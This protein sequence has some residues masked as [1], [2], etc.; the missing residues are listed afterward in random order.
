[1]GRRRQRDHCELRGGA[2]D[3]HRERPHRVGPS[4]DARPRRPRDHDSEAYAFVSGPMMVEEFTGVPMSKEELGGPSVH[5]R[6][7]GVASFVAGD[8]EE[9]EALAAELLASSPIT[10]TTIRRRSRLPTRSSGPRLTPT[11]SCRRRPTALMTSAT[12]LVPLSTTATCSSLTPTGRPTSSR[13]SPRSVDGPS[14]SSPTSRRPSP[15]HSTSPQ[16]RKAS[17]SSPSPTPSTD[18]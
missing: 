16:A 14:A 1:M 17:G 7:S 15:E 10:P 11:R 6:T 12:L 9:A 2:L 8:E 3:R 5:D 13:R 4:P 18:R